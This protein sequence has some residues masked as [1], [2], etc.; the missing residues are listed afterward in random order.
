MLESAVCNGI[1][2]LTV[3]IRYR[4]NQAGVDG[5]S[6]TIRRARIG[7]GIQRSVNG[8]LLSIDETPHYMNVNLHAA[9]I[10]AQFYS[11]IWEVKRPNDFDLNHYAAADTCTASSSSGPVTVECVSLPSPWDLGFAWSDADGNDFKLF[12]K[13]WSMEHDERLGLFFYNFPSAVACFIYMSS[14]ILVRYMSL[15][16]LYFCNFVVAVMQ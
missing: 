2:M 11:V 12:E 6:E 10:I 8:A 14:C 16:G 13:L 5:V 7:D 15:I 4:W 1:R 9:A 3:P